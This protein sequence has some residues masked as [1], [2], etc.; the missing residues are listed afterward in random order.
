MDVLTVAIDSIQL[1]P[2]NLRRHPVRNLDQIKASL[3]RFQQQRPIVVDGRG[4]CICGNG[5]LMA[6]RE[7]GWTHIAIVRTNLAGSEA[8]A[9]AI[10]DNRTGASSEWDDQALSDVLAALASEDTA[11]L[12]AT[13][14]TADDIA[15]MGGADPGTDTPPDQFPEYDENIAT[16]HECPKCHFRWSGNSAP[17]GGVQ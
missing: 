17:A 1:D 7:L 14:F 15:K 6:A 3:T 2:A 8:T 11:L 5:T 16:E 10:A 4:I 13:G 9:Y 12:N